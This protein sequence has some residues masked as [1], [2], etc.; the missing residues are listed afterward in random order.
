MAEHKHRIYGSFPPWGKNVSFPESG[1]GGYHLGDEFEL[2]VPYGA[3]NTSMT[4]KYKFGDTWGDYIFG[5]KNT[6]G[7]RVSDDFTSILF[8]VEEGFYA[9]L[10]YEDAL[11][12]IAPIEMIFPWRK[13]KWSIVG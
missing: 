10:T 13:Y 9:T 11:S 5:D 1:G 7:L 6:N 12:D 8:D 4:I 2:T 3:D